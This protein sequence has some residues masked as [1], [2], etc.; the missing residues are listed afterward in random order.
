MEMNT[1]YINLKE[2]MAITNDTARYFA[3]NM[4]AGMHYAELP[5]STTKSDFE[6]LSDS[7]SS[8]CGKGTFESF[9]DY[10]R[11]PTVLGVRNNAHP[12]LKG[13]LITGTVNSPRPDVTNSRKPM[14]LLLT[15]SEQDDLSDENEEKIERLR[16]RTQDIGPTDSV[17]A[18]IPLAQGLSS[19]DILDET[20]DMRDTVPEVIEFLSELAAADPDGSF[21]A[22]NEEFKLSEGSLDTIHVF[23]VL[24]LNP[25][26]TRWV[27]YRDYPLF[28]SINHRGT[29][30]G[31]ETGA[32]QLLAA[33]AG[34]RKRDEI[35]DI[36]WVDSKFNNKDL[37][38][39]DEL[40][41]LCSEFLR[42]G[43][44][45]ELNRVEREKSDKEP[46]GRYVHTYPVGGSLQSVDIVAE[47]LDTGRPILSQVTFE[48]QASSK[49][50]DL[51]SSIDPYTDSKEVDA[52]FFGQDAR[53]AVS[54]V[55]NK[56][57]EPIDVNEVL[58][59]FSK[60][61]GR[62]VLDAILEVDADPSPPAILQETAYWE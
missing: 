5:V 18:D 31:W 3:E 33:Y 36:T 12:D 28:G 46:Y 51:A 48:S 9:V 8:N 26:D 61:H 20:R 54:S 49:V 38:A 6:D 27:W 37:I 32:S 23:Q 16:K 47:D 53:T 41:T 17:F 40:E 10:V 59:A 30:N 34:V 2:D 42:Q 55:D 13:G 11:D 39:A 22:F 25:K 7:I 52:W 4:L 24:R 44:F 43:L 1:A 62:T 56:L 15:L 14:G 57:I 60:K 29:T 21:E 58:D 50:R 19:Q 45:T 35:R